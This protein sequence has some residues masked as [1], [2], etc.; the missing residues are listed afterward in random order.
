MKAEKTISFI[1]FIYNTFISVW[2]LVSFLKIKSIYK[3]EA[4][5]LFPW[6]VLVAFV[7]A[8]ASLIYWFYLRNKEKKGEETRFALAIS[9]ILL[10]LPQFIVSAIAGFSFSKTYQSIYNNLGNIK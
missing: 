10:L 1:A 5:I 9:L 6:Y 8:T 4:P 7:F 2:N 3:Y